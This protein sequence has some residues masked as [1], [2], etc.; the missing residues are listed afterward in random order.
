M[1]KVNRGGREQRRQGTE[2]AGNTLV[3]I[4]W[5]YYFLLLMIPMG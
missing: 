1:A 2:E 4:D 3:R 5:R